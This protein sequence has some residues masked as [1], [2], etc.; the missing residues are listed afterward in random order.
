[1][2]DEGSFGLLF[3]FLIC[4]PA[5]DSRISQ[6][7]KEKARETESDKRGYF[8]VVVVFLGLCVCPKH[9]GLLKK[10]KAKREQD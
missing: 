1:M 6:K 4:F 8:A 5:K 2:F 9:N 10:K 7:K 3:F